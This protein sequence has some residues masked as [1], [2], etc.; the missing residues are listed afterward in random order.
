VAGVVDPRGLI[1]LLRACRRRARRE[2]YAELP[3]LRMA[4]GLSPVPRTGPRD[5]GLTQQD[6]DVLLGRPPGAFYSRF[7]RGLIAEPPPGTM[8]R[9]AELLQLSE[10]EWAALWIAV[11]GQQPS[12]SVALR[13]GDRT[14]VPAVWRTVVMSSPLPAYVSDL[15]WDV[16]Y[17]NEAAEALWGAVPRNIL[18]WILFDTAARGSVMRQWATHWAPAAVAQLANALHE[19]PEHPR[20]LEMR[21]RALG[22]EQVRRLWQAR[23]A[24]PYVHPDGDRRPM[25]HARAR[26]DILLHAAVGEPKA[27]PGCRVVFLHCDEEPARASGLPAAPSGERSGS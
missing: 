18:A 11:F 10:Q 9:V 27:A 14:A 12:P 20:L 25:R 16:V 13:P 19:H 17:H 8:R 7:E 23:R 3:G 5:R 15:G 1:G 21:E 4:A 26:R 22:D 2:E 24:R 6:M